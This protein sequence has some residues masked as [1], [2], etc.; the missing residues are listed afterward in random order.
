MTAPAMMRTRLAI[1]V[2]ILVA[3]SELAAFVVAGDVGRRRRVALARTNG[4]PDGWTPAEHA[5][6]EQYLA[7]HKVRK[8][9]VGAGTV[10]LPDWLNT[11]IEPSTPGQVYLDATK[12]LPFPDGSF[13]YVYGEQV[14]EHIPF[15]D[16][17]SFLKECYRILEPGGRVRLAT[18]NLLRIIELFNAQKTPVQER[19]MDFEI[20][21]WQLSR[22]PTPETVTLNLMVRA[23]GHQFLYD[24]ASL[25]AAFAAAGFKP[26][27][28]F[29]AE[30]SDDP[31]L[32]HV[33][34]H[35]QIGG[36]KEVDDYLCQIVEGVR[37]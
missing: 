18:P 9:Q 2:V 28:D 15:A 23:W 31:A 32:Q 13:R 3:L 35:W 22:I 12:R 21:R 20:G 8:L 33:E 25:H 6:V 7:S 10:N 30:E 14:I 26:T 36:G 24:P 34:M 1:L 5:V 27:F 4:R 37:P 11:D 16:A 17:L 29:K 19:V